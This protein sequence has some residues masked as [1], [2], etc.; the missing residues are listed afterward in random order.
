MMKITALCCPHCGAQLQIKKKKLRIGDMAQCGHCGYDFVLEADQ[1][2]PTKPNTIYIQPPYHQTP[3][4]KNAGIA[5]VAVMV[6]V[7]AVAAFFAPLVMEA[8]LSNRSFIEP[9]VVQTFRTTPVSAPVRAFLEVV[10]GKPAADVTAAEMASIKYLN[11]NLSDYYTPDSYAPWRDDDDEAWSFTYSFKDCYTEAS[12][13]EDAVETI[14]IPKAVGKSI[15]WEDIQCFTGLT[16]LEANRCSDI[17]GWN[18]S[19][20]ALTELKHFGSGFNQ[21][22]AEIAK[23]LANPAQIRSL[24]IGLRTQR[25]VDALALFPNLEALSVS[26]VFMEDIDNIQGISAL[27][28]LKTLHLRSVGDISW[29]SVLPS[30]TDLSFRASSLTDFDVLYGLPSL[31]SLTIS[32]AFNLRDIGFVR[33]MPKLQSFHLEHSDIL[34]LEPLR[35]CISLL[36]LHLYG[37]SSLRNVDAL[38]SL[39]SLQTLIINSGIDAFPSLSALTHLRT[40]ELSLSNMEAIAENP[41]IT[42]LR[43]RSGWVLDELDCNALTAFPALQ[44]LLLDDIDN[45]HNLD[46]LRELDMLT[47]V[48]LEDVSLYNPDVFTAFFNLPH[49]TTLEMLDCS[50]GIEA[51]ALHPSPALTRLSIVKCSFRRFFEEQIVVRE[52][53]NASLFLPVVSGMTQ[54]QTLEL[55]GI[56]LEDI[57]FLGELKALRGLNISDN[58]VNDVSPLVSLPQLEWLHC[59]QNPIQNIAVI[60]HGVRV[61]H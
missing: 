3:A 9:E 21:D 61:Y 10:F 15:D 25:D 22:V 1:P 30:L 6:S 33:G 23:S 56:Q 11:M 53:G 12:G 32:A 42:E 49:V 24:S 4:R 51:A 7:I 26:Y 2:Q 19:L 5:I 52:D 40:A 43:V 28:K 55:P 36:T 18:V 16:F 46:A 35:D 29:L 31:E 14:F 45:L 41:S 27:A 8:L 37:N 57:S 38:A 13:F 54:L 50:L 44:T 20:T 47:T 48:R 17:S 34:S 58:Y 59:M 60:P 39:T